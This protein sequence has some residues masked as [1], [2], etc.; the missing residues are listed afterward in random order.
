MTAYP[1]SQWVIQQIREATPL[2]KQPKY[3]IHDNDPMFTAKHFKTLLAN[4][5]IKSAR[6]AYKSPWQNGICERIIRILRRDLL[7]H[8]IPFNENHLRRL[9]REYV[10]DYY[11]PHRTH[12]VINCQTPDVKKPVPFTLVK[13]TKLKAK[14]F[15]GGLYHTYEKV[16]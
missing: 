1:N 8:V 16:A 9:L 7:D 14:P 11:N 5:N 3:L 15:L 6:T 13:D 12:Q 2:G 10:D 4:M